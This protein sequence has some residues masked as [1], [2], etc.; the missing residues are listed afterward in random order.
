[1]IFDDKNSKMQTTSDNPHAVANLA[2]N[3]NKSYNLNDIDKNSPNA[4]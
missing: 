1:V 3:A 4:P 2:Y